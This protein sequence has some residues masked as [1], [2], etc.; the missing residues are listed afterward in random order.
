MTEKID[1][2]KPTITDMISL[3][4]SYR[5][6][7]SPNGEKIVYS[8]KVPNRNKDY[9]YE[10][11]DVYDIKQNAT[12]Q[13]TQA[14]NV[15]DFY[16]L[17]NNIFAILKTDPEDKEAKPQI[18]IYENLIGEPWKVTDHKTGVIGF[19]PFSDGLLFLAKDPVKDEAKERTN[20][21][22]KIVHFEQEESSKALYYLN[23]EKMK[24]Y[25][26][27]RRDLTDDD[28]NKLVQPILEVSKLLEEPLSITSFICS[29]QGDA[30]YLNCRPRDDLVYLMDTSNYQITL[31][32]NKALEE[33]IKLEEE[34]QKKKETTDTDKEK[35]KEDFSFIGKIIKLGLPQNVQIADISPNGEKLLIGYKERDQMFYTQD[36]LG[37]INIKK[38]QA[39]LS[40]ETLFQ[41]IVKITGNLDRTPMKVIW[42][43]KGIFI[44]HIEGTKSRILKLTEKGEI[45]NLNFGKITP[46]FD[47]EISE[48]GYLIFYG[49]SGNKRIEIYLTS[50]ITDDKID[51]KQITNFSEKIK[52]WQ[53]PP[54]ETIRWKSKDGT[55]IEG[56]LRKPID[57]DSNKKYP[58]V[59]IV[60]GG[61]TWFSA[62]N[63]LENPDFFIY[64]GV[65]FANKGMLVLYP[66]YRGSIGRGQ[67]FLELNKDNLG[68]GDLWDLEG[69]I[70][71]L[72][73]Q[74]F[75]DRNRIGC[76]GWSQGGY[77][78]SFV[79]FHSKQ[80]K[81]V[82]VGA[83][84]SDW[85]TYH[86][87]NDIPDFT[88]HYL[89]GSPFRDRTLYEKT[90]PISKVKDAQTPMLIQHGEVDQ[91][92]PISNAKE[93]YR[94]LKEMKVPVELVIFPGMGHGINKPREHRA[95]MYQNLNWFN[96]YLLGEKLDLMQK[97]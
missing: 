24:N 37:L 9:Y 5:M 33:Y 18:Y 62:E 76:M 35:T 78:S 27:K 1:L 82:S 38:H 72:D 20:E 96:H 55:E 58:L 81:A 88:T 64:P 44:S 69:A 45:T 74:G 92:V 59:F 43:K 77:I 10:T 47:F 23:V 70:D 83:G 16:W 89:S 41:Q 11:C 40:E 90:S 73:K 48:N 22:G 21:F 68:V 7:I 13:L 6:K 28:A 2:I 66:N 8:V 87:S 15:N 4:K 25:L 42:I 12:Y 30:I 54:V 46:H 93:L 3:D 19:K 53:I 75:L 57:F 39:I 49:Y 34:K 97:E 61:P 79:A 95:I 29:K 14:I 71:Y 31:D 63:I 80:F 65:Q 60:H 56:V 94:G 52:E 85:Y 36:D 50:E 26:S 51:I 84:V 67:A 86:I 32:A 17:N 91:R